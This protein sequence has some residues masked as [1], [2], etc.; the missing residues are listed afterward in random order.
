MR[1]RWQR[2]RRTDEIVAPIE[3]ARVLLAARVE[4]RKQRTLRVGREYR[5]GAQ[6]LDPTARSS[7]SVRAL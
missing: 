6:G 1:R 4:N 7:S 3:T 5:C 2:N